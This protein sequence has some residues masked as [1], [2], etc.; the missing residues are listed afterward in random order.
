MTSTTV[1]PPAADGALQAAWRRLRIRAPRTIGFVLALCVVIA[2]FLTVMEGQGL[3]PHL[4]YSF[5]TGG[6]CWLMVDGS[7]LL[8][9]ALTDA[10]RRARGQP[11][12]AAGFGSG[13]RGVIP[14]VLV[15]VVFGPP[16][17]L[18]IADAITGNHSPS[19]LQ[20]GAAGTRLTFAV[21]IIASITSVLVL[22]T[23]ERLAS[24][25]AQAAT[26]QRQAAESQLRLL[27][28]QL[29]PHMLFNTLANLRVLI[30]LDP[31]RAQAM[32]DRLIAY[33]RSTLA[34]S[35]AQSHPLAAEFER[36]DDYL[37]LMGVRMGPRLVV[38][39][40]LPPELR[41]VPVPPLLLQPLVEN[42]IQHGLEPKVD[43]GRIEVSARRA[44]GRL[45]LA[46]R[47]SGVGLQ[48][49]GRP[50]TG[51][52]L[53]QVRERLATVYGGSAALALHEAAGGGTLAEIEIPWPENL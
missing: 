16:L 52:G 49:P 23:M 29:E 33:L 37:A 2:V 46:V 13:W 11:L 38:A 22:S 39:L 44:G 31:E 4:V 42:S 36:I 34:A 6:C 21:T 51:F 30:G 48:A 45:V 27:Q 43:G 40:D 28:S 25:R 10:W 15:A 7:R 17:G 3:A 47:D 14:S 9:A 32:L 35:R 18:T 20:F 12:D 50:G 41:R 53:T 1:D 24:A 19:L 5:A 8:L 26:A